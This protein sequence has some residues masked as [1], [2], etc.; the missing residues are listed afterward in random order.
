MVKGLLLKWLVNAMALFVVV[1]VVAGISVER[2]QT[3]LVGALALGLLNAFFRPILLLLTLPI[4]VL[5]LGLFTLIIN[6]LI[7]YL[8]AW[9]IKGF[10]VAGFWSAFVAALVFSIVSFLL[11]LLIHADSRG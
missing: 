6:G 1:N 10:Y 2:W 3:L 5:T 7:F 4:N 8:A 11:N 9:M